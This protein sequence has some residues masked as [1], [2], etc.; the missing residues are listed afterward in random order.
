LQALSSK[1]AYFSNKIASSLS[2]LAKLLQAL[3]KA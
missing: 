3:A 1:A 2:V